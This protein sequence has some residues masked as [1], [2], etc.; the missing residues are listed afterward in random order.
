MEK[1]A[2]NWV[3]Y[4]HFRNRTLLH[5][6]TIDTEQRGEIGARI[7]TFCAFGRR[8]RKEWVISGFIKLTRGTLMR[9]PHKLQSRD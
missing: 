3:I 8:N 7:Q 9:V 6:D 5:I 4:P 2:A 1:H